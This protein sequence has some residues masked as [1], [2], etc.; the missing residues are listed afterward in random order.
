MTTLRA[1]IS[2]LLPA[3]MLA[4]SGCIYNVQPAPVPEIKPVAASLPLSVGIVDGVQNDPGMRSTTNASNAMITALLRTGLFRDVRPSGGGGNVDVVVQLTGKPDR[5]MHSFFPWFLPFCDPLILGCLPLYSVTEKFTVEM[6]A[7][8]SGGRVYNE[9]GEAELKCQG[10]LGCAPAS[11]GD[12]LARASALENGVAK[13]AAD[14]LKDAAFY[15]DMARSRQ[16][17]SYEASRSAADSTPS[18]EPAA[19]APPSAPASGQQK[20]WWQN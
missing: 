1:K 16:A 8:V 10:T 19:S 3:V 13:I 12:P 20:P 11:Q 7:Q 14:F 17:A 6:Q 15:R 5:T 4:A 18:A 9:T 2:P